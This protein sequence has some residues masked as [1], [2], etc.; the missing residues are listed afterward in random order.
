LRLLKQN[1]IA[2]LPAP[3]PHGYIIF[4][5]PQDNN[6]TFHNTDQ[7]GVQHYYKDSIGFHHR[8]DGPAV[9]YPQ[10]SLSDLFYPDG[11]QF[12]FYNGKHIP[13]NSQVEYE[14]YLKL[15]AFW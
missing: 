13:V 9:I 5:M 7:Y 1:N 3:P 14:R 2:P 15:K 10:Y 11:S 6:Y 8:L 12:W 4:Y